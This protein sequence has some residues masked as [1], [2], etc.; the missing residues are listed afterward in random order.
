MIIRAPNIG[1]GG[2]N[3]SGCSCESLFFG[4][5]KHFRHVLPTLGKPILQVL[6]N[7]ETHISIEA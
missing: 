1:I 5:L 3:K 2:A 7:H 4:F 6:D